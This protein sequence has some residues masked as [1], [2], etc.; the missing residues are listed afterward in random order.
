L[1]RYEPAPNV[2]ETRQTGRPLPPE[3]RRLDGMRGLTLPTRQR[4]QI[5]SWVVGAVEGPGRSRASLNAGQRGIG[6][7]RVTV[8]VEVQG[9]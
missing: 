8:V 4:A 6:G 1:P 2:T 9:L 5:D 7:V 3:R